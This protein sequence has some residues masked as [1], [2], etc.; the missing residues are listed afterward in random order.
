MEADRHAVNPPN[1]ALLL[2]HMRLP[3]FIQQHRG[4]LI[5]LLLLLPLCFAGIRTQHDWGDDFAQYINQAKCITEGK[6]AAE[7]GYIYNTNYP[8]LGPAAYPGGFPLILAPVYAVWGNSIPAFNVYLSVW[9][10]LAGFIWYMVIR[11]YHGELVS[12]LLT[13]TWCWHPW[14]LE[15]KAEVLSDIPFTA[16]TGLVILMYQRGFMVYDKQKQKSSLVKALAMGLAAGL[17]LAIRVQGIVVLGALFAYDFWHTVTSDKRSIRPGLYA[18]SATILLVAF[19]SGFVVINYFISGITLG[20]LFTYGGNFSGE[21]LLTSLR[22]NLHYYTVLVQD[23]FQRTKTDWKVLPLL[24]QALVLALAF[25]G[26][27]RQFIK[28]RPVLAWVFAAYMALLLVYPYRGSGFRFLLPVAPVIL[29]F[30]ARGFASIQWGFQWPVRYWAVGLSIILFLQLWPEQRQAVIAAKNNFAG[31]QEPE[32][33]EAFDYIRTHT[34]AQSVILFK[35]PRALALYA[36]RKAFAIN[37]ADNQKWIKDLERFN[38][39]HILVHTDITDNITREY[40]VHNADSWRVEWQNNKFTLY[41]K[42]P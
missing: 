36:E 8:M 3:Q 18:N 40:L 25:I 21:P 4:G 13:L 41:T 5:L 35:K 17:L 6:P 28:G 34:P 24:T 19:I 9:L 33:V 20:Q 38:P 37:P 29:H 39:S 15:F 10:V 26:F 27:F 42:N 14:T 7:T 16:L 12:V 2:K 32:S 22:E 30:A 1:S 31:P 23:F 11:R